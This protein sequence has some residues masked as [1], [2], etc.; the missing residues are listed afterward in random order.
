MV[1]LGDDGEGDL[2]SS[3]LEISRVF[4][5]SGFSFF[6][7]KRIMFLLLSVLPEGYAEVHLAVKI[8]DDTSTVS[9]IPGFFDVG[10]IPIVSKMYQDV[11]SGNLT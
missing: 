7:G 6:A 10:C 2:N 11:P 8:S 9:H 5:S 4:V 1:I 3:K